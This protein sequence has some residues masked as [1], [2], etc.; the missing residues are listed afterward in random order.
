MGCRWIAAVLVGAIWVAH[1]G[2]QAQQ[3]MSCHA[4]ATAMD[5]AVV[6][7]KL[8]PPLKMTG[9]GNSYIE[10]TVHNAEAKVWFE[11]GLNL[12]HDFWDYEAARAFEQAVRVD[13][14]CAMCSWGLAKALSFR[15][16]DATGVAEALNKAVALAKD[17][18]NASKSERLYIKAAKIEH[19]EH[20]AR[21]RQG[22]NT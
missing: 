3:T 8:P 13:P 20:A 22:P 4:T 19:Q 15:G 1:S 16:G 18:K 21:S 6:P 11:Q 7:E 14:N 2:V 5:V 9:I 10:I 12:L 17:K